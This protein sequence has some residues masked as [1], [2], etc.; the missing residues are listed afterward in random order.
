MIKVGTYNIQKC[1]ADKIN[2]NKE[3]LSILLTLF[4]MVF[5]QELQKTV[6]DTDIKKLY[7][8]ATHSHVLSE[9]VGRNT[10]KEKYCCIYNKFKLVCETS[11]TFDD[12]KIFGK[13]CF[14]RFHLLQNL[15]VCIIKNRFILSEFTPNRQIL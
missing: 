10:Y 9:L 12:K 13:D 7:D 3:K 15:F 11:Y 14:E 1:G 8:S 2:R 6:H 5:I 4:D